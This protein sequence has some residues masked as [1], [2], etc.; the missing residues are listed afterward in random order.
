M[1]ISFEENIGEFQKRKV[2][3]II[4]HEGYGT[5]HQ[6]IEP[7][8]EDYDHQVIC[9]YNL[10]KVKFIKKKSHY[11]IHTTGHLYPIISKLKILLDEN[12]NVSVFLHVAPKYFELKEKKFFLDYIRNLQNIYSFKC[13][14]PSKE[15]SMQYEALGINVNSVQ[16]GFPEINFDFEENSE[17]RTL[18]DTYCNKYISVCTSSDPRY[19]AIKGLNDFIDLMEQIG[20]KEEA[21]ILGFDGIYRGVLC[22][23]LPL[24]DFLYVLSKSKM[25]IQ[26][27]KT[28]SYNLTAIQ[29]KRLKIPIIVSDIDGHIDCMKCGHNRI[30]NSN[31]IVNVIEKVTSAKCIEQN[32]K[33]SIRR[34][35]LSNFIYSV[36]QAIKGEFIK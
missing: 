2:V 9:S 33:D 21:L 29:A 1:Q 18:L 12:V 36:N 26:L 6:L 35:S 30:R 4:E 32:F 16:L 7:L 5:I 20:K 28:E 34:E 10:V 25:Y 23:R 17:R 31:N 11:I 3:H 27:S 19:I 15:V 24:N 8:Q 14:C 13:L 22:K